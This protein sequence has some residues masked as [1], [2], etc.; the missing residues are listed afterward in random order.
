MDVKN[1]TIV[2]LTEQIT[3]VNLKKS[4]NIA[5]KI[6]TGATKGSIDVS[7]AKELGINGGKRKILVK[8]ASGTRYRPLV[9]AEIVLAGK[10]IKAL[11][12]L[13]DRKNLRYRMLIGQNILKKGFLIDPAKK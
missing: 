10:R 9:K 2:G 3:I 6:D 5:A 1:K 13:A 11:F 7:L 4:K 8:S 12:N